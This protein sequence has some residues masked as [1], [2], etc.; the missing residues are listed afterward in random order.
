MNCK[1]CGAS[2]SEN[3]RECPFCGSK[4]EKSTA[5]KTSSSGTPMQSNPFVGKEYSFSGNDLLLKGRW[6]TRFKVSVGED[7]LNFE[8]SPKKY[9]TVPAIMLEDI[10]GIEESFHMRKFN[11]VMAVLGG[12][13]GLL[14]EYECFLLPIL[15]FLLYRERK[16][17]I[18]ARNGQIVTIYSENKGD[19]EAFVADMK[20]ITNIKK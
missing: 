5:V 19:I 6:S 4:I 15:A 1:N 13:F 17:K 18:F 9:N 20:K 16:I 2:V 8:A 11:I 14:G 7:R 12:I 10:I 3:A